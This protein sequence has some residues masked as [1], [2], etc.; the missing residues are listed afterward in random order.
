[1]SNARNTSKLG[2]GPAFSAVA[3]VDQSITASTVTKVTLGSVDFD[4][5]SAF[6]SGTFTPKVAGYY[7]FNGFVYGAGTTITNVISYLYK[8]GAVVQVGSFGA[9][10][11]STNGM[12]SFSTVIYMNGTTDYVELFG[13][14][15]SGTGTKFSVVAGGYQSRFSGCLVRGA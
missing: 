3:T 15:Q 13:Y 1:M 2:N 9:A 5:N 4:T 10:N 7:Q 14:V 8:N 12:S 11:A 6:A